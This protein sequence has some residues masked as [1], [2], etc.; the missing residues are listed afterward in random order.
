ATIDVGKIGRVDVD[1]DTRVGVVSTKPGDYRMRLARGTMHAVIW[2]PPG[3]FAVQT[4]SS[5]AVDLGCQYSLTVD[6]GGVGVVTVDSGWVGF[7]WKGREA[8]IPSGAMCIT[9]PGLGPGTPHYESTSNAFR[10]AL[11]MIDMRGGSAAERSAGLETILNE[12][13]IR[14]D[15]TL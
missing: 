10:R 6:D 3:Q 13:Q 7:A 11:T 8:F 2:A 12:A 9:R 4:S 5:T 1:P 15:I 14:D